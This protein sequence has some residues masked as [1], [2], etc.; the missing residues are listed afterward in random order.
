MRRTVGSVAVIGGGVIGASVAYHLTARGVRDVVVLD[1]AEQPGAGSTGRA[2][3]GFR[4]QFASRTQIAL[5]QLSLAK[6]RAFREEL[7]ADPGYVAA[8][9]LW[10]A[11]TAP[12]LDALRAALAVQRANG[13]DDAEELDGDAI[14]AQNPALRR[15]PLAGATFCASDGFIRPLRIL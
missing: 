6:L 15:E 5:S 7:G 11:E 14:A 8:G 4:V 10:V 3:G 9:Y 13:V 1:R 2:T 12:E